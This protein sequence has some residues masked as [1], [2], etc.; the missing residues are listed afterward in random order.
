MRVCVTGG[1]GFVGAFLVRELLAKGTTVQVLARPSPRARQ[2]E[3]AGAQ[4]V[5]GDLDD[6]NAIA[7]AVQ[8]ADTVYHLAAKVAS[9]GTRAEY[10]AANVAA[11]ERVLSA[12]AQHGAGQFVHL[13]SLAVYGPI[14]EGAS[15]DEDTPFDDRPE[16]RDSYAES[17]IAADL[18]VS[19]FARRTGLPT[20]IMRPGIIFGPGRPL[21]TGILGFSLG[22][23]DIV[24]GNPGH[25]F[26]LNYLGNLV[27]AIQ[28][29]AACGA[30]LRQFN[31][32]DD[33][34][35]TLGKY[36]ELRCS[37]ELRKTRFFSGWPLYL[38]SPFAEALRS[39]VPMGDTRL[40]RH[41]LR[42]AL[43]DRRYDTRRIRQQT[44]WQPRVGLAEALR[45]SAQSSTSLPQ[46]GGAL[47]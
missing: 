12:C 47:R 9:R 18:L 31:V 28:T 14:D 6:A 7:Q 8:G 27:D 17:K 21:P 23:T 19:S 34:D 2:L 1:T 40:S 39:L 11:T 3:A 37:V 35:L 38:A 30:G 41:Q 25:H 13:S 43:E 45:R 44:G 32:L 10:F 15:I 46:P 16:L 4:I 36:H 42:R 5:G 20:L 29:A 22:K 24:F 26:P 33:D